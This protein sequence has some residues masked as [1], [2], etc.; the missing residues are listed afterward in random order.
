MNADQE[1]FLK[2]ELFTRTLMATVQRADIYKAKSIERKKKSTDQKREA[3]RS[4]LQKRLEQIAEGYKRKVLKG[5]HVKN[6]RK[7]ARHLSNRHKDLLHDGRFRIGT[8]QKALNLYLKFLWCL[9]KIP[10]PPHCPFDSR[11]IAKLSAYKGPS[12]TILYKVTDYKKLIKA[13]EEEAQGTS[14]AVWELKTYNDLQLDTPEELHK[15]RS[16]DTTYR[17]GYR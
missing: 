4:D 16:Q 9:G 5:V 14:L 3:F 10:E 2:D 12:W 6:I 17:S 8:A 11:I 7:L 1:R 15:R 13:A